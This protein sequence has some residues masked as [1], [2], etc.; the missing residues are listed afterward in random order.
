MS[1][2]LTAD[3]ARALPGG[4]LDD[5]TYETIESAL[6]RAGATI[7]DGPRWLTL[8]ER[9]DA[10]GRV[11]EGL[12]RQLT[13]QFGLSTKFAAIALKAEAAQAPQSADRFDYS[14]DV[15]TRLHERAESYRKSGG[16]SAH[17][18]DLLDEAAGAISALIERASR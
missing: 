7:Q 8:P 11:V 5:A 2:D 9:V 16:S 10:L 12:N 4:K 15:I 1:A 18:A 14:Q 17:T 13:E 3:F 6:D